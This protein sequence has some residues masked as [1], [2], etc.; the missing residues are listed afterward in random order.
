M[1]VTG[2]S[3]G[4]GRAIALALG[5]AGAA[6]TL[7]AR[8]AQK[9]EEAAADVRKRGGRALA[10]ALDVTAPDAGERAVKAAVE[11]RTLAI[12]STSMLTRQ[13]SSSSRLPKPDALFTSTSM[14]STSR[15]ATDVSIA[16]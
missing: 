16:S 9:L 12:R 8:D 10:V 15:S 11:A 6:V 5:E 4:I 14:P 1:L 2:A 3:R 7:V 13:P